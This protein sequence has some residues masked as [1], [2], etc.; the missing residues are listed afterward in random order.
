MTE[1]PISMI[2]TEINFNVINSKRFNWVYCR[3]VYNMLNDLDDKKATIPPA[4]V[5]L[6]PDE[7]LEI[8]CR[9]AYA[10][11]RTISLHEN[12]PRLMTLLEFMGYIV[13]KNKYTL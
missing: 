3:Q 2:R 1:E 9:F 11:D 7:Y 10:Y 8:P 5:R 4:I 6:I 12:N 13:V